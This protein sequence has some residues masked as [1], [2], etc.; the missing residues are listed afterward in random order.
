MKFGLVLRMELISTSFLKPFPFAPSPFIF[1]LMRSPSLV[2]VA[3]KFCGIFSFSPSGPNLVDPFFGTLAMQ[4]SFCLAES[5][6]P[7]VCPAI[8]PVIFF[9]LPSSPVCDDLHHI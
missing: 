6:P 5:S 7:I 2:L 9:N 8:F 1:W 4:R 3:V